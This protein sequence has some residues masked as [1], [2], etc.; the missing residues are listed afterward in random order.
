MRTLNASHR[1]AIFRHLTSLNSR[2]RYMRFGYVANDQ[3]IDQ[4]VIALDFARDEVFGI[5]DRSLLLIAVAH[6]AY[7][8][9]GTCPTSAELGVSVLPHARDRGYGAQLFGY[10]AR[11]AGNRNVQRIFIHVLSENAPMIRIAANA[12]ASIERTGS[13]SEA[14]LQLPA[15]TLKSRLSVYVQERVAQ[16]DY[17]SKVRAQRTPCQT[18]VPACQAPG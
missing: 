11:H 8:I 5:F 10:A 13:E 4:Y 18:G 9:T 1:E 6:L 3:H 17:R 7:L 14:T 2:D 12:G 16:A 15:P